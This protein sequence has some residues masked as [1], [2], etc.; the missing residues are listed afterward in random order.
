[1]ARKRHI[2]RGK[3]APHE[4]GRHVDLV[5]A[6][7]ADAQHGVVSRRQLRAAGVSRRAI[8]HRLEVCRLRP[9]HTGVYSVGVRFPTANG[10]FLAAVLACNSNALLSH[11]SAAAL[12]DLRGVPNG[13]IDVTIPRGGSRRRDGI[14]V[15]TTRSLHPADVSLR[16]GMPCTALARTFVDLARMTGKD[17]LNRM[18]EKSVRLEL[19]DARAMADALSRAGGKPG[20]R[21]LT[22]LLEELSDDPAFT[23]SKME[24]RM[25]T[26]VNGSVSRCPS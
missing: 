20:V 10:R 22:K 14:V 21:V 8:D 19:F 16:H 7:L 23:R 13:R 1:V 3:S 2:Q 26:L 12:W 5:I 15:H 17:E 24:R 9:V 11:R 6:E 25:L 4:P 18:L